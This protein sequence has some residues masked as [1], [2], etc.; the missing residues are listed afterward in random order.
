MG[1]AAEIVMLIKAILLVLALW[2]QKRH[3]PIC[4]T[5]TGSSLHF[6]S[7]II[8]VMKN[9]LCMLYIMY[10]YKN[11]VGLCMYY[12]CIYYVFIYYVCIYYACI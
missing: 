3:L 7:I 10:V 1:F 11:Y 5:P 9:R 8:I 12:V 2:W 4:N 6:I